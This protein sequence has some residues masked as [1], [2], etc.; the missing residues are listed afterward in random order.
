[1]TKEETNKLIEEMMTYIVILNK[2]SFLEFLRAKISWNSPLVYRLLEA[3]QLDRKVS[4]LLEHYYEGDEKKK[5]L[6]FFRIFDD[7]LLKKF[8]WILRD[9]NKIK[10]Y[11]LQLEQD[12][13]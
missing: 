10:Q 1:M 11:H 2:A 4:G 5:V 6:C 13:V 12:R 9:E 7:L 3:I 8:K